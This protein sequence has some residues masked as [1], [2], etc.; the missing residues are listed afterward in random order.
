[1][2][3]SSRATLTEQ[4]AW[5]WDLKLSVPKEIFKHALAPCSCF[6]SKNSGK[7]VVLQAPKKSHDVVEGANLAPEHECLS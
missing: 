2:N 6:D 4:P 5:I 3:L 7:C 1:M